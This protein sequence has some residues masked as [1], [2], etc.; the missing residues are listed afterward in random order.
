V[1]WPKL[2]VMETW[3]PNRTAVERR[4]KQAGKNFY[5]RTARKSR[6]AVRHL[7]GLLPFS[8]WRSMRTE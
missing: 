2:N 4:M 7:V 1:N 3:T 8:N 6:G 5:F